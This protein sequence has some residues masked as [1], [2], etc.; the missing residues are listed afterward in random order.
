MSCPRVRWF[1]QSLSLY[2]P[3]LLPSGKAEVWVVTVYDDADTPVSPRRG[4]LDPQGRLVARIDHVPEVE[5]L[6]LVCL[7]IIQD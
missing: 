2:A 6:K 4:G 3:G 7:L 5:G 1:N